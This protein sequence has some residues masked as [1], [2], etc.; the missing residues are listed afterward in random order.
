MTWIPGANEPVTQQGHS[1]SHHQK[2]CRARGRLKGISTCRT[3]ASASKKAQGIGELNR[4]RNS[5]RKVREPLNFSFFILLR[6][7]QSCYVIVAQHALN[8]EPLSCWTNVFLSVHTKKNAFSTFTFQTKQ[9][10]DGV[11]HTTAAHRTKGEKRSAQ[12]D[13]SPQKGRKKKS[14]SNCQ[15][16]IEAIIFL[17]IAPMPGLT[18]TRDKV[19]LRHVFPWWKA[20]LNNL[21]Q[22]VCLPCTLRLTVQPCQSTGL[23]AMKNKQVP[24]ILKPEGPIQ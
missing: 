20:L 18:A 12:K 15:T 16:L 4:M 3:N 2:R 7:W 5:L 6:R 13:K 22:R 14:C 24:T 21:L 10:E 8:T 19:K 11:Q 17:S 23:F 1:P 9:L